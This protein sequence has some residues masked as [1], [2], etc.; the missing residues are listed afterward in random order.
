MQPWQNERSF[1]EALRQIIR[2]EVADVLTRH[3]GQPAASST[4]ADNKTRDEIQLEL[5]EELRTSNLGHTLVKANDAA[6]YLGITRRQ[7]DAMRYKGTGPSVYMFFKLVAFRK[8]VLEAFKSHRD[9]IK[10]E[11]VPEH[12]IFNYP[13]K[14]AVAD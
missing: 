11:P 14:A 13:G 3:L 1:T 4:S 5:I 9:G 8:T 10:A 2:E 7:L 6:T 12:L